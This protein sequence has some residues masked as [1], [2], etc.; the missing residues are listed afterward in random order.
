[1]YC[2]VDPSSGNNRL[3]K[4]VQW[5]KP[6]EGLL[7]L[8]TDGSVCNSSGLA[9]CGGLLRDSEGQWIVGFVKSTCANSSIAAKLLALREG[10]S[11][12]VERDC[13]AV[14]IELLP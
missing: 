4:Q 7:K 3:V 8:N 13:H 5:L 6:A 10:L 9:G 2:V 12:C 14:E 11:L 1:M